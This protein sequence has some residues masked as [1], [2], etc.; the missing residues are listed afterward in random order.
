MEKSIF[1]AKSADVVG[2]VKLGKD[3]NVWFQAVLRGDFNSITIGEGS[4]IQDGSVVHVD[5]N[6]PTVVGDHV[7]VGHNCIIHGCEIKDNVIIGM[8]ATVMNDAVVN[9]NCIVGANSLIT[10]G[11]VIPANSLV[12]GSPARVIRELTEE[13]VAYV[14][15]NAQ[16]YVDNKKN[17]EGKKVTFNAE[18][19]VEVD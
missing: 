10:E 19:Y 18:G 13:E 15:G 12:M 7:T 2:K 6:S 3:S 1:I 14:K 8:G 9:E 17:Y 5:V 16:L 4:N 11:K